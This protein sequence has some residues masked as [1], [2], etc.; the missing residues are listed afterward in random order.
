MGH[1]VPGSAAVVVG[2]DPWAFDLGAS[3]VEAS[4]LLSRP[5]AKGG[6][7]L[8]L[9]IA[10]PRPPPQVDARVDAVAAVARSSCAWRELEPGLRSTP[11]LCSDTDTDDPAAVRVLFVGVR[12]AA[13]PPRAA[14]DYYDALLPGTTARG[15]AIGRRLRAYFN[16]PT[17]G[18]LQLA[19]LLEEPVEASPDGRALIGGPDAESCDGSLKGDKAGATNFGVGVGGRAQRRQMGATAGWRRS[20][21]AESG[22]RVVAVELATGVWSLDP[23]DCIAWLDEFHAEAQFVSR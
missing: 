11:G 5:L 3:P 20:S 13:A 23:R 18:G 21:A 8:L 12:A 7:L 14:S 19:P 16:A 2:A 4:R 17:S 15:S 22:A 1:F 6:L 10:P 9:T